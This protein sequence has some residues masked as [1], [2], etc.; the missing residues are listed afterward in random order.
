MRVAEQ[1]RIVIKILIV[2]KYIYRQVRFSAPEVLSSF[3]RAVARCDFGP[4]K[5][6]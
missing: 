4:P 1:K 6:P 2:I 5:I 3:A